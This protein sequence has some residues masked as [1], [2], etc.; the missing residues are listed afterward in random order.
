[1]TEGND[2]KSA[3]TSASV[4]IEILKRIEGFTMFDKVR[5][6]DIQKPQNIKPL[7]LQLKDLSLDSLAI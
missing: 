2:R 7:L 3:I 6:S 5:S 1:M 4:R